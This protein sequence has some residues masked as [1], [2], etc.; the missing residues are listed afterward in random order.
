MTN[1]MSR[2]HLLRG[3]GLGAGFVSLGGGTFVLSACGGGDDS[4]DGDAAIKVGVITDITGA[5][6]YAGK[7]NANTARLVVDDINANGGLLER[8]LELIVVDSATD[9]KVGVTKA[10]EL[11]ERHDVDIVLGGI[12]SNMRDAIK[13]TIVERGDKLYIYPQLYEGREC[14]ENIFC[15]G[16]TPN[17]QVTPFVPWLMENG[18]GKFYLPSADYVW[19]HTLN[20]IVIKEVEKNGGEIVDEEYFPL[21][22]TDFGP[23]VNNIMS[24]GTEVVF[25]TVVPPG[26]TPFLGQL[27]SAGFTDRGGR[28][29]C[30]YFDENLLNIAQPEHMEGLASCLDYFE[31]IEDPFSKELADA[32]KEKFPDEGARFAAG[33]AVTGMYRGLRMWAKAVGEA[34]SLEKEK[35]RDALARAAIDEGPGGPSE[36]VEGQNHA[37]MN[38]YI[39]VARG[40]NYEITE[41]LG[42]IDPEECH[43]G[44]A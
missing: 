34:G 37:R 31:A 12:N 43:E 27:F 42:L 2:R 13:S 24:S 8:Q 41:E 44:L 32:Y 25:T 10:Q 16:P 40:G 35:V 30:V 22:A 1:R 36:M 19:P 26:I 28:L 6:G 14:N 20:E 7:A 4:G 17:Q 5:N 29:A 9:P 23:T 15:T 38:M 18:G 21:D 11:V 39:A 33:S 3:M